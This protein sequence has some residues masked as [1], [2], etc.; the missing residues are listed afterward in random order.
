[1]SQTCDRM[2]D[3]RR[4]APSSPTR[5]EKICHGRMSVR[6]PTDPLL[7]DASCILFLSYEQR[8]KPSTAYGEL[9]TWMHHGRRYQ[10][11]VSYY[12]DRQMSDEGCSARCSAF[13]CKCITS[14]DF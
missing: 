10:R 7:T 1:M 5:T 3:A 9:N 14:L 2:T 6:T 4:P 12:H 11:V 13:T 8:Y